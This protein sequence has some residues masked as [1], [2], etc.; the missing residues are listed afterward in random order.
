MISDPAFWVGLAFIIVTAFLFKPVWKSITQALDQQTNSIRERIERAQ[1][2]HEEARELLSE[3]Q[4]KINEAENEI[5]NINTKTRKEI[6][7]I[8]E[9]ANKKLD[10]NIKRKKTQVNDR[11]LQSEKQAID[12]IKNITIDLSLKATEEIINN[13]M[14]QDKHK[15]LIDQSIQK[16]DLKLSH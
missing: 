4:K 11:I 1:K 13:K 5:K 7:N 9:E 14:I 6:K 15:T 10:E 12:E 16:L 2:L 8:K 3:Y